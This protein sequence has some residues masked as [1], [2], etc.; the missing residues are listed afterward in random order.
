MPLA[1]LVKPLYRS[2]SLVLILLLAGVRGSRSVG[3]PPAIVTL[4]AH[5][6]GAEI[7]KALDQL[8]PN[9][10]VVLCAGQYEIQKPLLL[11][12]NDETLTGSGPCT[13]LHLADGA[14]CPVVVLGPPLGRATVPASH[15]RL[16][17]LVID[18][19][20]T[21]QA[22]EHWS[23]AGD[24]AEVNNNGIHVWNVSDS[25]IEHVACRNCRSGGLVTAEVRRLLVRDFES[26]GNQ[27]DGLACYETE[28]SRFTNLRLHDNVAAGISLD[29]AFNHNSIINAI[30]STNDLGI[31]MRDSRS[32]LFKAIQV[33]G[34]RHDGVFMAEVAE[35]T[36]KGW[37]VFPETACTGNLFENLMVSDCGGRA[38]RVNDASCTNN[39]ISGAQF[40]RNGQGGLS[41]PPTKPVSLHEVAGR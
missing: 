26:S 4:P 25:V 11:Q 27:F 40:L 37:Q 15:L 10:E 22:T 36:P 29:L 21:H 38:F 5:V 32:N 24:G 2:G 18:G 12:H 1:Q 34:S 13:I 17:N 7:Q 41:Q 19:N 16:A 14:D 30:L 8:P 20:R 31:F 9:G 3:T 35:P 33:S 39:I 28:D 23:R 6:S